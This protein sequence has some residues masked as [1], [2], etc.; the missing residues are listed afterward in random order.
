MA[1]PIT[2][3]AAV[4]EVFK[5]VRGESVAIE[6]GPLAAGLLMSFVFGMLAISVLLRFLRSQSTDVFVAYRLILAAIVLVVWVG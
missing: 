6:T 1:T 3:A 5:V 4:Y 2:A